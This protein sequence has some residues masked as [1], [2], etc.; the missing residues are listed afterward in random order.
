MEKKI[1]KKAFEIVEIEIVEIPAADF[2][3]LSDDDD[4]L[5]LD[6]DI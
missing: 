5:E 6:F 1:T 3:S 2:M 4:D